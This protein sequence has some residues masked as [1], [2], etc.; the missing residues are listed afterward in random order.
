MGIDT[1]NPGGGIREGLTGHASHEGP[2]A[3]PQESLPVTCG[4]IGQGQCLYPSSWASLVA[5]TV[6]NLPAIQETCIQSLDWEDASA[7]LKASG[8]GGE[9]AGLPGQALWSGA[10]VA[11][12]GTPPGGR[13]RAA[14]PCGHS[15]R[16]A[17]TG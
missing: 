6:K 13:Q 10:T 12:A 9:A 1:G 7:P 11:Q 2:P 17:G 8:R 5:Q 4:E 14:R 3:C 15:L 16:T